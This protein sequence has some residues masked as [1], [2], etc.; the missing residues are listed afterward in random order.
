MVIKKTI[1]YEFSRYLP[2]ALA[3]ARGFVNKCT[4]Q[5]YAFATKV[6]HV[7]ESLNSRFYKEAFGHLDHLQLYYEVC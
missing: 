7:L 6:L 4:T 3:F 2:A 5:Y 1:T